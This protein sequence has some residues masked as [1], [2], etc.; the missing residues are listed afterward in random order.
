[1]TII[2]PKVAVVCIANYCRSPVAEHVL[3]KRFNQIDF[4][5]AGIFPLTESN[6]DDR[7]RSFL[8]SKEISPQIH[9][10]K[11]INSNIVNSC[12]LILALDYVVLEHL[13]REFKNNREKIKLISSQKPKAVLS[14]PYKFNAEDYYKIMQNLYDVCQ[15]LDFKSLGVL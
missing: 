2:K 10:P 3:N 8:V 12:S 5:S 1:M 15:G 4:I 9:N 13:N 7:S 6:M 14:D 11:K